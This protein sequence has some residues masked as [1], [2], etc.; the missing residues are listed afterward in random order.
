[1]DPQSTWWLRWLPAVAAAIVLA[2]PMFLLV[3]LAL[4]RLVTILSSGAAPWRFVPGQLDVPGQSA[5]TSS[6]AAALTAE[7]IA[8]S[9]IAAAALLL[10][11]V[12]LFGAARAAGVRSPA[13]P[14]VIGGIA[15][16]AGAAF[17]PGVASRGVLLLIA[18]AAGV[19]LLRSARTSETVRAA[20]VP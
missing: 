10:A 15:V 20:T 6:G 13:L 8:Q 11:G 18:G 2:V 1:A 3:P 9:I 5:L 14:A 4:L 7:V 12:V 17:V 19:A 16:F